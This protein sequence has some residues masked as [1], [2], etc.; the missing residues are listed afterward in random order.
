[1]T[2]ICSTY[3]GG[4]GHSTFILHMDIAN[5]QCAAENEQALEFLNSIRKIRS[6]QNRHILDERIPLLEKRCMRL[7]S[8]IQVIQESHDKWHDVAEN[9]LDQLQSLQTELEETRREWETDVAAMENSFLTEARDSCDQYEKMLAQVHQEHADALAAVKEEHERELVAVVQLMQETLAKAAKEREEALSVAEEENKASLAL[10]DQKMTEAVSAERRKL[11]MAHAKF[12]N[13]AESRMQEEFVRMQ[14]ELTLERNQMEREKY[15]TESCSDKLQQQL[16]E[17]KLEALAIRDA[18]SAEMIKSEHL[19]ASLVMS[20]TK[21]DRFEA[22]CALLES[23]VASL[24]QQ[25]EQIME[26]LGETESDS[27][28]RVR[29]IASL[30]KALVQTKNSLTVAETNLAEA[31]LKIASLEKAL[32]QTKNSLTVAE[33][34]FVESNLKFASLEKGKLSWHNFRKRTPS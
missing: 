29:K 18:V 28:M 14:E 33:T 19:S 7:E 23:E 8:D 25:C 24:H 20:E 5:E 6:F 12:Q 3:L 13:D 15:E 31:N 4:A 11:E 2:T 32:V 30:E 26:T 10:A 22:M 1:M 27:V 17:M 9:R 21:R 16:N 34:N